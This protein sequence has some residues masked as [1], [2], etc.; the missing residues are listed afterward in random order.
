MQQRNLE[1]CYKE[2]EMEGCDS[3]IREMKMYERIGMVKRKKD[4]NGKRLK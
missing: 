1:R 3:D 2:M 4:R